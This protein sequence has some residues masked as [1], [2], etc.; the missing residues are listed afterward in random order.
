MKVLEI[1]NQK[2]HVVEIALCTQSDLRSFGKRRYFFDWTV[3]KEVYKLVLKGSGDVLGLI[4]LERIPSEWRI[5]IRLLTVSKE[6]KGQ[7]KVYDRIA[8]NL[9]AHAAK[10]AVR[11]YGADACISLVPKTSIVQHYIDKYNMQKTGKTLS[12]VVPELLDLLMNYDHD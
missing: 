8:G 6:N 5:H 9:I 3:E 10:I 7:D 1:S 11:E 2:E 4:S 12:M